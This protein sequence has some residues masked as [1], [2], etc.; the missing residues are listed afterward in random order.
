MLDQRLGGIFAV[1]AGVADRRDRHR[2]R[3]VRRGYHRRS[4]IQGV[5]AAEIIGIAD[6]AVPASLAS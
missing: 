3:H 1:S 4:E 2:F 6:I 5:L